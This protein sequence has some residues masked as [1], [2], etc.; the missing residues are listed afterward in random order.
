[1]K[2]K[3]TVKKTTA[4]K[5]VVKKK[6]TVKKTVAKRAVVKK[7]V[8]KVKKVAV[9]EKPLT[10]KEIAHFR[11]LLISKMNEIVGDVDSIE[12]EAL[13]KD[14]MTASGDLSSMPIHMADIGTDV[15]EQE[16]ALN[17]LDGERKNLRE[18]VEALNRIDKGVYGVCEVVGRVISRK[19]LKAKPWAK[20]CIEYARLVEKGVVQQGEPLPEGVAI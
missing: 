2:K 16:F 5:A 7:T 18:I 11:Q 3:T 20:Y 14:R 6:T 8:V 17:L 9:A 12:N 4:K 15:Y 19:R 1:M 13:K 10:K